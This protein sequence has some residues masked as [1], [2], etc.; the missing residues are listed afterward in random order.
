[1]SAT[2]VSFEDLLRGL[3]PCCLAAAPAAADL[4]GHGVAFGDD[5]LGLIRGDRVA[6]VSQ[7]T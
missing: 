1:L 2:D 7:T 5:L 6:S 4:L 3:P